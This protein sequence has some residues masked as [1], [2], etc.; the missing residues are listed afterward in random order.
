MRYAFTLS[1]LA[2]F[3]T[4]AAAQNALVR[5]VD[6]PRAD[7]SSD[8]PLE[9]TLARIEA[10]L[11]AS[12]E[13]EGLAPGDSYKI[14]SA[15]F[16]G[17]TLRL[18]TAS[19]HA[20]THIAGHNGTLRM[21]QR[22]SIEVSLADLDPEQVVVKELRTNFQGPPKFWSLTLNGP[23][24]TM[25]VH[26][27]LTNSFDGE[28]PDEN[29]RGDEATYILYVKDQASAEELAEAFRAAIAACRAK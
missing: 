1:L 9:R 16:E 10:T 3:V 6:S 21:T 19:V 15:R 8:A 14:E 13:F 7:R 27:D 11:A 18:R 12:A 25:V 4:V 20:R 23:S 28:V 22:E 24:H 26:Y 17:C 5:P 29:T 2:L